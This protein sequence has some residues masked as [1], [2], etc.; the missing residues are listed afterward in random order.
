MAKSEPVPMCDSLDQAALQELEARGVSLQLLGRLMNRITEGG[1][2]DS[3][4]VAERVAEWVTF[5]AAHLDEF[6]SSPGVVMERWVQSDT[7]ITEYAVHRPAGDQ[8]N[9][10]LVEYE[11]CMLLAAALTPWTAG[12][13]TV[14]GVIGCNGWLCWCLSNVQP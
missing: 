1:S 6:E 4:L 12:G 7:S 8:V 3:S 2:Q 9:R 14:V 11:G 5:V 13:A 10:C